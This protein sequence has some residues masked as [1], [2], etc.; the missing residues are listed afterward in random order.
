VFIGEIFTNITGDGYLLKKAY[1]I[2]LADNTPI[3]ATKAV[4]QFET[5]CDAKEFVNQANGI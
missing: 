1:N 3:Y 5:V 2:M 4:A